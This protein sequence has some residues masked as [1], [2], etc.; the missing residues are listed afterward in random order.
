MKR[1]DKENLKNMSGDELR[2][3]LRAL[4][5]QLFQIKFNRST[6]PLENPMQIRHAR[7]KI[8]MIKTWLKAKEPAPAAAAGAGKSSTEVKK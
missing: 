5:K 3:Q 1:K 2:V 4:E 7:R 6:S 8:A